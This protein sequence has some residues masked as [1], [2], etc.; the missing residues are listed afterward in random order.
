MVL[1]TNE[2]NHRNLLAYDYSGAASAVATHQ[3]NVFPGGATT[4][5]ASNVFASDV[6]TYADT[7]TALQFY[8]GQG[9]APAKIQ[10][11]IPMYGRSFENTAGLGQPFSGVG[12]GGVRTDGTQG[13]GVWYYNQLPKAGADEL[14]DD[15]AQA[16]YSYDGTAREFI[17][18]DDV[19]SV[20][21]KAS[22]LRRLGLGGAFFFEARGDRTGDGS[23]V[24]T[25]QQALGALDNSR[26]NLD[27][28]TSQYSNIRDASLALKK[29]A[30]R[31]RH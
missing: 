4:Y 24:T 29:K 9:I 1:T 5:A 18:Y 27:Y 28:P 8:I 22:Y 11:G 20:E 25:M 2:P 14:Y 3:S 16:A 10:L 13:A 26:N 21:Y 17:T 19:A 31:R 23:L 30:A 6:I 7:D 15:V 12:P